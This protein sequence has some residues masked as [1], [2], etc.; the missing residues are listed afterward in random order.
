MRGAVQP[1]RHRRQYHREPDGDARLFELNRKWAWGKSGKSH[2][3]R[4]VV[5][6]WALTL[7]GFLGSTGTVQIVDSMCQHH[8]ITG[9]LR[10][11]A[12]MGASL[13]AYGVVWIVKF[14][15]FNRLV[16]AGDSPGPVLGLSGEGDGVP[17]AA[18]NGGASALELAT[19]SPRDRRRARPACRL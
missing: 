11:L 1:V 10:A 17:G 9:L 2:L 8:H 18:A 16:F 14:V 19:E 3:W 15:I 12:I 13:F 5:P 4:E 7:V 6:F